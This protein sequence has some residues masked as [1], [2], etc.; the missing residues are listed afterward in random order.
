MTLTP[1]DA[2]ALRVGG[3]A[4]AVLLLAA[5]VAL[6]LGRE[7]LRLGRILEPKTQYVERLRERLERE[8]ALRARRDALTKQL[9]LPLGPEAYPP[10]SDAKAD[11]A[12]QGPKAPAPDAKAASV[13]KP[14]TT[15]PGGVAPAPGAK[16]DAAPSP[17]AKPEAVAAKPG[18][19]QA[20]AAAKP[21]AAPAKA[22]PN[23]KP[24][25]PRG[26]SLAAYVERVTQKSG[27]KLQ[28]AAP[29]K[30][31]AAVPADKYQTPAGLQLAFET[32]FQPLVSFLREIEQGPRLV[33]ISQIELRQDA[34]KGPN[35]QVI[36]VVTG[37]EAVMK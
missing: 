11:S 10:P 25:A 1:R 14:A 6:P 8:S 5:F 15:P 17:A 19:P 22:G 33:R 13:A 37:Y 29:A 16:G 26:I 27:I 32:Q 36:M 2:R 28:R 30:P 9:G 4:A 34:Q 12:A 35:V 18:A 23:A 24:P 31:V 20:N 7:W 21:G 3:L